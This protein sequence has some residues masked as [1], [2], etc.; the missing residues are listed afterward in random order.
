MSQ[1]DPENHGEGG[2]A[3]RARL[4]KRVD[5]QRTALGIRWRSEAF[6]VQARRRDGGGD[7][8]GPRIGLTVT[9]KTGGAVERNR[10]RRRL[11]EALRRAGNLEVK[12]DHDYVV[13]ARRDALS[14]RFD[15]LCIDLTRAFAGVHGKSSQRSGDRKDH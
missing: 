11:R 15:V 12:A 13:I 14:R 4:R 1:R 2:L 8:L 7:G 10:I 3:G 6:T 5:F 9:R